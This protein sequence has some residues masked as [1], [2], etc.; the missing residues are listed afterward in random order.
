MELTSTP[1]Q[2]NPTPPIALDQEKSAALT[3][4]I[5][6]LLQKEAIRPVKASLGEFL[7]PIFLVPKADGSWRPV[8]NLRDLNSH[9]TQHHFK[10][11][12]IRTVKGL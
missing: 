2:H 4:E 5:D 11:E 3:A 8:I 6:K 12:G 1:R 9:I 10:M 7:S